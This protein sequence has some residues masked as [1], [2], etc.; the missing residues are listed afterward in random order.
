MLCS[1]LLMTLLFDLREDSKL[2]RITSKQRT[3]CSK[4]AT[5]LLVAMQS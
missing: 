5:R 1:H 4:E 2:L 3:H